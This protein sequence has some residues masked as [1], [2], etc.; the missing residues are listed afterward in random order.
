VLLVSFANTHR[1]TGYILCGLAAAGW[2]F[3]PWVLLHAEVGR[4]ISPALEGLFPL[5]VMTL[6]TMPFAFKNPLPRSWAP[7][8]MMVWLGVSDVG[9]VLCFF[10]AYQHTSV[11]IAVLTHY[12]TPL[13]VALFAPLMT[14]EKFEPK[15]L[16]AAGLSFVGLITLLE[17]WRGSLRSEDLLGAGLGA[18]S[19]LFY[20]S[21]VIVQKRISSVFSAP[22]FLFFHGLVAVP[23]LVSRVPHPQAAFAQL[24]ENAIR[25]LSAGSLL[26]GAGC[27]LVFLLGLRRVRASHASMLTLMEPLVAVLVGAVLMGQGLRPMTV[28]GGVLVLVSAAWTVRGS[29]AAGAT[30][31]PTA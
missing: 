23:L 2:G 14:D 16:L 22:Q 30:Q 5:L 4:A 1:T 6:V 20:A 18:L 24:S 29:P 28:L 3:W 31:V 26:L 10:S 7:W 11:A 27:G 15:T 17:P 21:N 12:L 8:I 25:W 19:A 9:N 13:L